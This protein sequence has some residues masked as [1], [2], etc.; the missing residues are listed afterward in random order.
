MDRPDNG[1]VTHI[2]EVQDFLDDGRSCRV[3]LNG[4]TLEAKRNS[5]LDALLEKAPHPGPLPPLGVI[6]NNR[7][8]G[9]SRR[10]TSD[11]VARTVDYGSKEGAFIFR[12]TASLILFTAV[13]ELFPDAQVEIGQSIHGGYFLELRNRPVT[14]DFVGAVVTRMREIVEGREKF[15]FR[16]LFVD[17]VVEILDRMKFDDKRRWV[18]QTPRGYLWM[19]ELRG[20]YDILRGPLAPETTHIVNWSLEAYR[21]GFILRFPKT[22]G[23]PPSPIKHD[24]PLLFSTFNRVR[25][26]NELLGVRNVV[27][28]TD[29]CV[30]GE[31]DQLVSA[32]EALFEKRIMEVSEEI[33]SRRERVKII[34]ISGPTSSGKTTFS[35]K[36][37]VFLR[38]MGIRPVT[39]SMDNYYVNRVDTPKHPDGS[40]NFEA[41]EA[42]DIELFNDHLERLTNGETVEGP[43]YDFR[44]GIRHPSKRSSMLLGENQML[45]IEGLHALNHRLHERIPRNAKFLVFV[46]ALAQLAIDQHNRIFTSDT[47]LLRRIVRDRKFRGYSAAETIR[48]WPSVRAGEEN[49][50]YPFQEDADVMVNSALVYEHGVLAPYAKRYL[51]EVSPDLEAYIEAIRLYEFADLFLPIF[52]EEV[53]RDSVLREFIGGSSFNY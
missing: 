34:F 28:L 2:M 37:G 25:K 6:V 16:R 18:S 13:H 12:R 46:S 11:C 3:V 51:L 21:H 7:L 53:P 23:A 52:P 8:T 1:G 29:V 33:E 38:T 43:I 20:F 14:P 48:T 5:R 35:K 27:D 41:P 19:A 22:N 32:S 24:R 42:L 10:V 4:V 50:I 31:T 47:R 30:R 40:Y 26:D 44:E 49:Y 15:G 36:L 45:L 9:L 39:L 17:E